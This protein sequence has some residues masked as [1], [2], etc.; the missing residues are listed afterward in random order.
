MESNVFIARA[1]M[2]NCAHP[3]ARTACDFGGSATQLGWSRMADHVSEWRPSNAALTADRVAPHGL[4]FLGP[5]PK[6]LLCRRESP[7][8]K[9]K[10]GQASHGLNRQVSILKV[11]AALCPFH[12]EIGQNP[13]RLIPVAQFQ[14]GLGQ[15]KLPALYFAVQFRASDSG[16]QRSSQGF[17]RVG[18]VAPVPVN[19]CPALRKPGYP[20]GLT[21]TSE[22]FFR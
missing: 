5:S 4:Q 9:R 12:H 20:A 2:S 8:L 21:R 18:G 3:K 17:S 16:E 6:V 11:R 19:A 1:P 10:L 15:G 22:L 14:F 13:P 7:L